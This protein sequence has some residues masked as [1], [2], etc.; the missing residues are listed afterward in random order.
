MKKIIFNR[1]AT[2]C[3]AAI[4]FTSCKKDYITGGV[5]EDVNKYKNTSTYD[6]L[7]LDPLYDTLVQ[8]IDN[9]GIKDKVNE[10]GTSFF[11]PSDYSILKYLADRTTLV[12]ATI[13]QNA[14]FALDSLLYYV[15]NNINGTKDS[16]LMY[17][18]K[19]PLTY[20]VLTDMGALYQT[21]LA[22]N[23][24]IVSYEYTK[25]GTLGYNPVVSGVPQLV[26]FTQLWHPYDLS[27]S[28]PA[29]DVP[30][31]IGVHTL[32]KSSGILTQNGVIHG[33]ENSH[34]LFFYGTKK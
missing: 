28:N 32:V 15:K 22:G 24:A 33:L 1:L 26:Y 21:E 7:K 12:Q 3:M 14:K 18:I 11:A 13:N 30:S 20:G 9:A 17:L 8:V 4:L 2:I 23:S 27:P 16:L 19:K 31:T 6:V 5:A 29:S 34:T 25:D 10:A